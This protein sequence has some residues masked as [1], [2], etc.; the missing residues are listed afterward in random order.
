M[1]KYGAV[2]PSVL[3][4][5]GMG[6]GGTPRCVRPPGPSEEKAQRA[7]TGQTWWTGHNTACLQ[8]RKDFL[9]T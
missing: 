6:A 5:G 9:E 7:L 2:F 8:S 4:R 3:S 1:G